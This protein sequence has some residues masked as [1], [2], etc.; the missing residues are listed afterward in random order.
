[1]TR[2][3]RTGL[4][5]GP[6]LFA[7][8]LWGPAGASLTGT[9]ASVAAT[10]ALVATWWITAALPLA[11][12]SLV[13]AILFPM[14][15]VLTAR[16]VAPSYM[17]DL[18]LLFVGA[19]VVA[20]GIERWG[21]HRRMALGIVAR[22]G[23]CPRRL[24]LGFMV[25]AAFLSLWINNTATTLMMLPIALAVA[26]RVGA[27]GGPP[28]F[29]LCLLLGTAYAASMGGIGTPVG[30]APNQEFLGQ[31]EIF[32]PDAPRIT[33]A[34]WAVA[35]V[36]LVAVFIPVM[37][38]LLTRVLTPISRGG[39]EGAE[40]V[41]EE[42]AAL[43]RMGPGERRMAWAFAATAL[44]WV[45]RADLVLGDMTI[46][47]WS[48]LLMGPEQ[49]DPAWYAV[50]K[51]DISDT[52]VALGM[53]VILFLA[54]AGDGRRL[55]D[56][57]TARGMPWDVV[58]LLGGGFTL[59]LGFRASGL[60]AVLGGLLRPALDGASPAAVV[61]SVSG[62][63]TFLTEVTS[64]TATTAVTMPILAQAAQISGHHPLL[65][66]GPAVISASCAFMLPVATPPN[67]VVFASGRIPAPAMARVGLVL[68]LVGVVLVSAF[69]LT[70]V[71]WVWKIDPASLPGWALR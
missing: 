33:F 64:N 2:A 18:V 68:N 17:R 34:E 70:W 30:T 52:T 63:M 13:P 23:G 21:L 32:F 26:D 6:V 44:L 51:N 12:T 28:R 56:W 48:R 27:A 29:G 53:A 7:L 24:V 41:A 31:L 49:A 10:T 11:A 47:G 22:V 54:P 3:A 66:M 1:M 57:E 55:M 37:W 38:W 39:G 69:F 50:H 42:R 20:L 65:L 8:V 36:P 25:A 71:S 35:F 9:Q 60:D 58:L 16:E 14:L 59:A 15:G 67:A 43:G 4:W 19:F 5:L 46:P 40:A 61:L 62:M 45:F